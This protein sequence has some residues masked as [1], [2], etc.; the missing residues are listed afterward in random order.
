MEHE[1]K[2]P[3]APE[4]FRFR[5][6]V[7]L[8]ELTGLKAKNIKE[9]LYHVKTVPGSVIYH[10][11]HHF[12]QQHQFLS[13]EPPNDFAYWVTEAL[14]ETKL[15]ERLASINICDFSSIRA[16]RDQIA[17]IIENYLSSSKGSLKEANEG[18]EFHLMK[19]VSFVF[20]TP[21]AASTLEEFR[22]A[23]K[24]ISIHSLYFHIFEARLRLESSSNDF[25]S[26]FELI[27]ENE[28][29]R[30][31]LKLDPYTHTMERLREKLIRFIEDRLSKI[32]KS[33]STTGVLPSEKRE[34]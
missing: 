32:A 18:E 29:A 24:K 16:I 17:G 34:S 6:Q 25:T 4:P 33:E 7:H 2:Q 23:L 20:P 22:N 26:W 3:K 30:K 15:G 28:L 9:L 19:S 14:N 21:Y 31:M 13:P 11:T 10:H 5:T 1:T 12:L 27:G 8:R